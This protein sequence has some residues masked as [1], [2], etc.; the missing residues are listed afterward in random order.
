MREQNRE[1]TSSAKIFRPRYWIASSVFG[2]LLFISATL[3]LFDYP[4]NF[5]RLR[6][7]LSGQ[8][9][10]EPLIWVALIISA[11]LGFF[12]LLVILER[13]PKQ[14]THKQGRLSVMTYS[15]DLRE[16]AIATVEKGEKSHTEIAEDFQIHLSTL[17]K[18]WARYQTS[19]SCA[20]LP[21]TGG[22]SRVLQACERVI[23]EALKKQ[24]DATLEE[25]CERVQASHSL[26]ASPSMTRT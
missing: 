23:R 13:F 9:R 5:R 16:R 2:I 8:V 22:P 12:G 4:L 26:S 11:G 10:F 15:Q 6:S 19:G 17:D 18:W 14:V 25:L 21:A 24:P 7:D 20:A 3:V 1:N